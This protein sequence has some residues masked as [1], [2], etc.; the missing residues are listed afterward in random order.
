[1]QQ[2]LGEQV[3]WT[4]ARLPARAPLRGSYVLARPFLPDADAQPLYAASHPP[5]G[6]LATW[7]YLPD[8]PYESVEHLQGTLEWALSTP[9]AVYFALAPLP[10]ERPLG[11]ASYMRITPELGVIEIGHVWFGTGLQRTTAA[12]EAIYLLLRNA[13]DELGYRRVEWKC[14]ALNAASRKAAER[15]GFTFEGV[16][17]KHMVVK[18]HNRDT[19]WFA[20]T[21]DRWPAIRSGF[22]AWL[23]RENFDAHARQTHS[24]GELIQ[25]SRHAR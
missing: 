1:M 15:F 3:D 24:L 17:H 19:A 6:D 14:N 7:T 22:E 12:T 10:Q 18:G 20:I 11:M 9:D 16:F 5:E 8:G 21:D 2:P 25:R 4:P 23:A 13:F